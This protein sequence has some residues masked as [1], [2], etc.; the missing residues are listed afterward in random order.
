VGR[1]GVG[2]PLR[3]RRHR[4]QPR[5]RS[6]QEPHRQDPAPGLPPGGGGLGAAPGWGGDWIGRD[7]VEHGRVWVGLRWRAPSPPACVCPPRSACP[8]AIPAI[9]PHISDVRPFCLPVFS[10]TPVTH[11]K[12]P[13]PPSVSCLQADPTPQAGIVPGAGR[14]G[15]R[16]RALREPRGGAGS[17]RGAEWVRHRRWPRPVHGLP[18]GRGSHPGSGEGG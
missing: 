7:G 14:R 11:L 13:H 10:S 15:H 18:L 16:V 4:H 5:L 8:V 12:P 2:L 9:P 3:G 1:G 17:D 6:R